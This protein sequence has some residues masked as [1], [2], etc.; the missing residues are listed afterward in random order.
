MKLSDTLKNVSNVPAG[1]K[2]TDTE[3]AAMLVYSF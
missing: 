3:T 1:V 2:N